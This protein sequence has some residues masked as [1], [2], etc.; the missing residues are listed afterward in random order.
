MF[1]QIQFEQLYSAE[2]FFSPNYNVI[3]PYIIKLATLNILQQHQ[4]SVESFSIYAE[5]SRMVKSRQNTWKISVKQEFQPKRKMPSFMRKRANLKGPVM[6]VMSSLT[7]WCITGTKG[8]LLQIKTL[9]V[10]WCQQ[11]LRQ[12]LKRGA[13]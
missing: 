1:P 13:E 11:Y 5:R 7:P 3:Q 9:K 12:L 8:Q 4:L 2:Y 6:T 10:M